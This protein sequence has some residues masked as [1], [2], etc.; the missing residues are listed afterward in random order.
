MK[1][2]E[3]LTAVIT[4][5]YTE[6]AECSR[7]IGLEPRT[8]DQF[9]LDAPN[10]RI[11]HEIDAWCEYPEGTVF[12]TFNNCREWGLTYSHGGWTFCVYEHRNSD[13]ICIEGCPDA[14]VQKYG[15]YGGADKYD[16]LSSDG[17]DDY[18]KVGQRLEAALR[19]A[20]PTATRAD[21]EKAM[22]IGDGYEELVHHS[23]KDIAAALD[24]RDQRR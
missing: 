1:F 5:Q 10:A 21:I 24:R 20:N 9:V 19:V 16:T 15:P 13:S 3:A 6:S 23:A 4:E 18:E 2:T 8:R 12:G 11:P 17:F 7:R 14:E 22:V